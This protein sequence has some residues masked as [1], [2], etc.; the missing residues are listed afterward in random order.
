MKIN[1]FLIILGW[2]IST[3]SFM[4]KSPIKDYL[5]GIALGLFITGTI[6]TILIIKKDLVE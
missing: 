6:L 5:S 4:T 1:L 3:V 2:V